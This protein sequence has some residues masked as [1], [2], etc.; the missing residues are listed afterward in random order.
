VLEDLQIRHY[1]PTTI[2]LYL[3]AIRE[4]SV[5]MGY[6][7]ANLLRRRITIAMVPMNVG[8]ISLIGKFK[9]G[10]SSLGDVPPQVVVGLGGGG[11]AANEILN[12]SRNF[13]PGSI[14]GAEELSSLVAIH[15]LMK[16][17]PVAVR[18][19]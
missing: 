12:R 4:F 16:C 2:R 19:S 14:V 17:T 10:A 11:S 1:S 9:L 15:G 8:L 13:Q 3:Y 7:R 5:R 18:C 6:L